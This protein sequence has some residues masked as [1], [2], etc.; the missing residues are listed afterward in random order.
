[1]QAAVAS[2][3]DP[4]AALAAVWDLVRA[5]NRHANERQPWRLSREGRQEALDGVLLELAESLRITAEAL[6]PF[7]PGTAGGILSQLGIQPAADWPAALCWNGRAAGAT[8]GEPRPLFP[9]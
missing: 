4:Q 1:V 2:E 7:L 8:V 3:L 5:A 6:R 9:R